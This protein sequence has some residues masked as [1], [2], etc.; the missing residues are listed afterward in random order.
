MD[1]LFSSSDTSLVKAATLWNHPQRQKSSFPHQTSSHSISW[2]IAILL[3]ICLKF[4]LVRTANLLL[5]VGMTSWP[6]S[7]PSA[8]TDKYTI[9]THPL[10]PTCIYNGPFQLF[11]LRRG[12]E[13]EVEAAE[14]VVVHWL[15]CLECVS[16][17]GEVD[18]EEQ[19]QKNPEESVK[20]IYVYEY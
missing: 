18:G 2:S 3:N 19:E 12:S 7:R 1:M 9:V 10:P 11:M 17:Q 5:R 15:I 4:G 6:E 8:P 16:R 13:S 14:D 20:T